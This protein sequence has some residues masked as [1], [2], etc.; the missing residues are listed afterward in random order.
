M[1]RQ[2]VASPGFAGMG[3]NWSVKR[4]YIQMYGLVAIV[5]L[6]M[7][8]LFVLG[9][10]NRQLA[11]YASIFVTI[12]VTI[13]LVVFIVGWFVWYS[14]NNARRFVISIAGRALT[15]DKR[16]GEVYQ[17][18]DARLGLWGMNDATMG[19][20]LHLHSGPNRFVLGGREHRIG[21]GTRLDEPPIVGVD[22]WL[23]AQEFDELLGMMRGNS[24]LDVRPATPGAPVRC[25]LF[26]NFMQAQHMGSFAVGKRRQLWEAA[27]RASLAID[28]DAHGIRVFDAT[29][30]AQITA[31]RNGQWTARP[32]T[33][34]YKG[35]WYRFLSAERFLTFA[36]VKHLSM[37]PE[38]VINL[39]GMPPLTIAGQDSQG[40]SYF[41]GN[42]FAWRGDVPEVSDPAQYSVTPADWLILV[43]KFGLAPYL[44]IRE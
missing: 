35:P 1:S 5:A 32:A 17:F 15:I 39:A 25:L 36:F 3:P 9:N 12:G 6:P 14:R 7:V 44:E 2:F 22:A 20:V 41:Q 11:E 42:R 27:S 40:V 4:S 19:T 13:F 30:N 33:Y 23:T 21:H 24:A 26:P 18:S 8:V 34:E 38:M 16:P 10:F 28:V 43:E 29:T 31:A 37:R